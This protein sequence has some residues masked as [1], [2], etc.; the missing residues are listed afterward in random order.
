MKQSPI[1]LSCC[2]SDCKMLEDLQPIHHSCGQNIKMAQ[3]NS[4]EKL[5]TVF[6][7][8]F[9]SAKV[10]QFQKMKSFDHHHHQR[11]Q[12]Q[13]RQQQRVAPK[14]GKSAELASGR[15]GLLGLLGQNGRKK[16]NEQVT[17]WEER[18][19]MHKFSIWISL[20]EVVFASQVS[21]EKG[22]IAKKGG[23]ESE[24]ERNE[25]NWERTKYST[26][27]NFLSN[28]YF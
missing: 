4:A 28:C 19:K 2:A 12:P 23:I 24:R 22:F 13:Q 9:C 1:P 18:K 17:K 27:I 3:K 5:S 8:S 26:Q 7:K 6:V 10:H 21:L 11:Q 25:R 15:P 14:D 16:R 20:H